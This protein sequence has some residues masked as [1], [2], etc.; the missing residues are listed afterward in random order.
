MGRINGCEKFFINMIS[1]GLEKRG[2]T[3]TVNDIEFLLMESIDINKESKK[4][5]MSALSDSIIY[6]DC[7][8]IEENVLK[9]CKDRDINLKNLVVM[10]Y[11]SEIKPSML[12][13][14]KKFIKL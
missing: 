10:W 5:Y 9:I 8:I 12:D 14:I 2:E 7:N 3:L 13:R 11:S 1:M 4:K 6:Y